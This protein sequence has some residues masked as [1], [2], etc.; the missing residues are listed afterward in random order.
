[1]GSTDLVAWTELANATPEFNDTFSLSDYNS[2]DNGVRFYR[3]RT[4]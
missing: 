2:G 4:P 1:M 3:I